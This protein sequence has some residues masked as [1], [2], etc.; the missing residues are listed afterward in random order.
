MFEKTKKMLSQKHSF[1]S[2]LQ[3]QHFL[4]FFK[5]RTFLGLKLLLQNPVIDI[6]C[7]WLI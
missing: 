4:V 7:A 5:N 6:F 2:N 1:M 3:N